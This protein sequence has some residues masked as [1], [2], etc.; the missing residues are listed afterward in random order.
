[1]KKNKQ[2]VFLVIAGITV[3]S[4]AS[5]TVRYHDGHRRRHDYDYVP[6]VNHDT[7]TVSVDSISSHGLSASN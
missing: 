3:I 1:M 2:S 6:R 5:C 4:L 7:Q